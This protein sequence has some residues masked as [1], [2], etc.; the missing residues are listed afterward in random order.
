MR[1]AILADIHGN[2]PALEAALQEIEKDAVDGFIVAGDMLV[3]PN[4]VEVISRLRKLDARMICGNN[5]NYMLRFAAGE[6]P[7]WWYTA[8]Q[9]SFMRWNYRRMDEDTLN[10][11]K[12]LHEQ[13]TI[14]FEG[15]DAIRVVHGSPRNVSE[16]I[17]PEKDRATLDAALRMVS[18]PVL[19]FGHTHQAWQMRL[20]GRLALN[21]GSVCS[22]FM[23]KPG[24]SYAILF[25]EN[26]CWQAELRDLQYNVAR[27]RKA[28]EDTGL[29]REV[30][31]FSERWLHDIESGTDTI[32]R[33]VEYAYRQ[34]AEAGYSNS[35]FVPD[36]IWDRANELFEVELAKGKINL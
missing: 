36:D 35:S 10:F 28:F 16:S 13:L 7:A 14:H 20:D 2:I 29:L 1:L 18:E 22:T 3:G 31:T 33:F 6:A 34:A 24:G 5:E 11:I 4:S 19:I 26:G 17:Y 21:P 27:I 25:W 32:Q 15:I 9:W 30:G 8:H 23:G 12:N